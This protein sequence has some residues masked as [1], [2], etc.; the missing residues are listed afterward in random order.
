MGIGFIP[1]KG[2]PLKDY[3]SGYAHQ[4]WGYV[5]HKVYLL[6]QFEEKKR[7]EVL[8][9]IQKLKKKRQQKKCFSSPKES[10]RASEEK[11]LEEILEKHSK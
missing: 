6:T 5:S 8:R 9:Q 4:A 10:I 11:R 2:K 1:W 7:R 3:A